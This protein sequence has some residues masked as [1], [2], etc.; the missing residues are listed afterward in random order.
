VTKKELRDR[1]I[2]HLKTTYAM[3]AV[4]ASLPAPG[5]CSNRRRTL[6]ERL[7]AYGERPP[8]GTQAGRRLLGS[9][10][11]LDGARPE[12]RRQQRI[13]A[14]RLAMGVYDLLE[15]LARRAGDDATAR[16]ARELRAEEARATQVD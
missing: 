8:R 2:A 11:D 12:L 15:R 7:R 9:L 14:G 6:G 1:L 13:A 5:A 10:G 16:A 3:E 4:L